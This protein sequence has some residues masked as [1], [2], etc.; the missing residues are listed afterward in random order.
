MNTCRKCKKEFKSSI[1]IDGR[2]R[3]LRNRKYCFECSPWGSH[4]TKD[5]ERKSFFDKNGK[6]VYPERVCPDCGV[7]HKNRG[8]YCYNCTFNKRT[9]IINKNVLSFVGDKCWICGY[10]KTK[11]NLCF[12][13]VDPKQKKF[14]LDIRTIQQKSCEKVVEEMKK[15]IFICHNC[16]G[17]IH[18]NILTGQDVEKAWEKWGEKNLKKPV[19]PQGEGIV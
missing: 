5:L 7:T 13:H 6:K 15:C 8:R 12:H 14:G 18:Y 17:E 16:H 4:N 2:R 11:K 1:I 3:N 10:N 19:D 9:E